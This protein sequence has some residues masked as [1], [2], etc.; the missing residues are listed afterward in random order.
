MK[1]SLTVE[2]LRSDLDAVAELGDEMVAEV[3]QRISTVLS[4]SAPSRLLELLSQVAA[5][6]SDELPRGH[7]EVRVV[8]DDVH[9]AYVV[10]EEDHVGP[11]GDAELS[12]RITLRL[13]DGLKAR[14]EAAATQQGLSVNGWILR[15]L[16]R[17]VAPSS[18]GRTSLRGSKRLQGFGTS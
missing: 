14:V 6:L 18:S 2:G 8:G 12:A 3:A 9:L 1:M 10:T 15:T 13:P 11:E 17:G 7:V 4:R 16:E 5:E